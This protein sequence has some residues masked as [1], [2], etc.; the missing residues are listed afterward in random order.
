MIVD[1]SIWC[2]AELDSEADHQK[3]LEWRER[4]IKRRV[5]LV[6]PALALSEVAGAVARRS[7]SPDRGRSAAQALRAIRTLEVV[8]P[9]R[10]LMD[11]ATEIA[12]SLRLR[13]ADAVYVAL[14]QLRGLPLFTWDIEV[15]ERAGHIIS[16]LRPG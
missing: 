10:A 14:A 16:V 6:V 4:Q 12:A 3:S 5:R 7:G 1:A 8:L 15:R 9:D 13:G 2:S 11:R